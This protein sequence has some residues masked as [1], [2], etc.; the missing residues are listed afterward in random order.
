[1]RIPRRPPLTHGLQAWKCTAAAFKPGSQLGSFC[2]AAGLGLEET[3]KRYIFSSGFTH[4]AAFS[5]V[6]FSGLIVWAAYDM[7]HY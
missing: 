6:P 1:M 5:L 7:S 3:R 4:E 2:A